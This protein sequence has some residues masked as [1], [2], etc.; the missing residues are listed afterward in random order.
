[1]MV[2]ARFVPHIALLAVLAGAV[3][4]PAWLSPRRADPCAHPDVLPVT[5]LIPGSRPEGEQRDRLG[6]DIIQWSEGRLMGPAIP[7]ELPL[8]FRVIR[9]YNVLKA[10]ERPLALL[11]KPL[12]PETVRVEHV[13][14]PGGPLPIHVVRTTGP[15]AFHL[16]AYLYLYGNEPVLH[17][18]EFQLRGAL[19]ELRE[20]RRPLTLILVGGAATRENAA[21]REELAL[22]WIVSAWQHY[23]SMCLVRTGSPNP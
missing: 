2:S 13:D 20:G 19:R 10:A 11:P 21:E 22:R 5:G 17:P 12:E 23:R 18:F 9:T 14:A 7:R 3:V 16:A 8:F 6:G 4:W 15:A 1:M